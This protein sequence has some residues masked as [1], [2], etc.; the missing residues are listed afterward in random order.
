MLSD[1]D[2]CPVEIQMWKYYV[3]NLAII[4][5]VFC[6]MYMYVCVCSYHCDHTHTHSKRGVFFMSDK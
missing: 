6:C 4:V 5:I 2:M 3:E 1:T